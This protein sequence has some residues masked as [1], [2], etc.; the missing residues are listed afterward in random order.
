[1]KR[2]YHRWHSPRLG[3]E[4]GVV[5]Y[6][7]WGPPLVGFPNQ[8]GRRVGNWRG[9]AWWG[10]LAEFIDAGAHQVLHRQFHQRAQFL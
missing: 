1:M 8:R 2:E 7:H 4:L 3:I 6:G 10:A 5:V 9:R